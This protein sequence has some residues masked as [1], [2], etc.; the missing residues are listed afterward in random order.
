MMRGTEYLSLAFL[1][2]NL[3]FLSRGGERCLITDTI[4][5]LHQVLGFIPSSIFI[6]WMG[7]GYLLL[8]LLH[9]RYFSS[10]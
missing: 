2:T 4:I 3:K 8:I 7:T 9:Y 1:K 5:C 6:F 10:F